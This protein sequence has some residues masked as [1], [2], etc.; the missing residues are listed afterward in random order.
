ML[1]L[2]GSAR[3]A[4]GA[5]DGQQAAQKLATMGVHGQAL[6][7]G[8]TRTRVADRS[9]PQVLDAACGSQ[10]PAAA[11]SVEEADRQI[12]SQENRG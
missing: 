10:S 9:C 6:L 4:G 3:G 8:E 11:T 1:M 12:R 5:G 7:T 2:R